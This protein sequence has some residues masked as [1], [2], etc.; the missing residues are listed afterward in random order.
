MNDTKSAWEQFKGDK[1]ICL[2]TSVPGLDKVKKLEISDPSAQD[3]F[4]LMRQSKV[5]I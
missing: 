4:R 1:N 5:Q 2:V 3:K